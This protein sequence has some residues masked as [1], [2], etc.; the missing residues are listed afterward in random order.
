MAGTKPKRP[1]GS[2]DGLR[3]QETGEKRLALVTGAN[4]GI[5]LEIGRQL[6]ERGLEV[7][8]T[9]R[10]EQRGE[11]ACNALKEKGLD[12]HFLTLDVTSE[13]DVERA[14]RYVTSSFGRLDVLIQ[15]AAVC[16]DFDATP[17]SLDMDVVRTTME[18]NVIGPLMLAKA[19]VPLM[20]KRNYGRIVIVSSGKGSFHKLA[21]NTPIYRIS[22][23]A[24]NAFTCVLA[25]ELKDTNILVNAMT[26]GWVRTRMGGVKAPRSV[27]EGADT[28]VWLALSDDD[29]PRG[30]FFR[31]REEFPW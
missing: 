18:T 7:I 19:F 5:G 14:A 20:K 28:A 26:P 16:I 30:M 25:D 17:T 31:D 6:A 9:A 10:N 3:S 1:D 12:V 2:T 27:E 8:L 21:A 4:R 11:Q 22:K 29:G 15:N 23:T 24:V 13:E